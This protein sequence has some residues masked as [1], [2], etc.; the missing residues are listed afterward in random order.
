M[1]IP[2]M[3]TAELRRLT[4]T[5]MSVIALVALLAVPIL[6]GGLYLWANQ[7][8]YGN[9]SHVP[10]ALVV[11]DTGAEI[12]GEQRNLGDE[13]ADQLLDSDTFEWHRV[14]ADQASTGLERGDFDFIVTLPAD[15]SDAVASLSSDSP[16][17]A[18]IEL[19]TNDA[20]NY[21]ASTIG[22]QAV[23]R[24]QASVAKKV[25]DEA[26]LT[27]LDALHTIRVN[28]VDATTGA[29]QLVDGLGTAKSGSTQLASGSAQLA[30]GTAK[31]SDGAAQLRDGTAQL[32]DG[33]AQVAD[34]AQQVAGGVDRIDS[35]AR[36]VGT[37]AGDAAAQLPQ[38]RADIAKALADAGLDQQRIDEILSR[39]DPVGDRLQAANTRV[40]ET[41]QQINTLDDGARQVAA[42]S[43][44][45][46]SGASTAA[47]GASALADGAASAATGAAQL[48]D[49]AAQL[50]SG[51]GQLSDG[52]TQLR[53]GLASGV[54]QIPDSD[55]QTRQAQA[56]TISD[57]VSVGST[58]VTKAQNYGA[59]LAPFFAA[60]AGWI[61][62]YALFLIVKPV[63]KRAVT[64]L[65]S[66]FRVTLAGWLTPAGLGAVQM[67]GLFTVLAV[68]LQFS[69]ANPWAALG[70]LL[71][72]S[73][74]YAAIVLALNVWLG[75]VGQFLGLVLMVLQLVTAGGTFPWQTL[76]GPLAALHHVLPMGYVVDAM[77]QVMYG[78][79][80]S[81]VGTDLLVLGAWM[82]GGV[83]L[84]AI[85][86]TRMTHHRTLRDLQPSLIG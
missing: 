84:A 67:V 81:R 34:G 74:T 83:L 72:A 60:L 71:F 48:R 47:D 7:D 79:D 26:G 9:L 64:A 23:A 6:Y 46:A 58:S 54:Q 63:S 18:S 11:D 24:I 33:S 37:I 16:R 78:G 43:A 82:V 15:F 4:S 77:R 20:N 66:P 36:Q 65:R 17:Q 19:R 80:I 30:D 55:D 1:K 8:P 76:P 28:L 21:L 10:V 14:D 86:V 3:I 68:A 44:Q 29:T 52:A 50:D 75:S 2:Q 39:L 41:V 22:S 27:L 5:R 85:G 59:G 32:R 53:D 62:I 57:P 73:A 56:D 45:V 13:A 61:G 70:I 35:A 25:T 42:G 12:N 38:A 31:L 51:L 40:Q 69:F 49:G